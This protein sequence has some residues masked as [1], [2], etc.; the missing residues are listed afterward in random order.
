MFRF[1]I[2]YH[3]KENRGIPKGY[4][5]IN[6]AP[7]YP[8]FYN[9]GTSR[10][11]IC[12]NPNPPFNE[13]IDCLKK[14]FLK[15]DY[16]GCYSLIYWKYYKEFYEWIKQSFEHNNRLSIKVI[17][18]FYKKALVE[19]VK[20]INYNNDT[21]NP[22][23]EYFRLMNKVIFENYDKQRIKLFV[24]SPKN[25]EKLYYNIFYTFLSKNQ[26]KLISFDYDN[27]AFGNIFLVFEYDG[28]LYTCVS[29]RGEIWINNDF[30]CDGI[31]HIPSNE[32]TKDQM[33]KMLEERV[34]RKSN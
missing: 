8:H 31:Y 24:D 18:R 1:C 19:W 26:A 11:L 22:Q 20:F 10:V 13:I 6:L 2:I 32:D 12:K 7:G 25:K 21:F 4:Y 23:N 27:K 34:F 33:I 30:V 29:D 3:N 15:T 16:I 5:T 9:W 28:R 14:C 17:K